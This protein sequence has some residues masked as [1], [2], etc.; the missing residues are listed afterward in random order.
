MTNFRPKV[1][2]YYFIVPNPK[3]IHSFA[4]N[5]LNMYKIRSKTNQIVIKA[6]TLFWIVCCQHLPVIAQNDTLRLIFTGDIMG[7]T[8][9]IKSAE[10]AKGVYDYKSCFQFVKPQL[11]AADLA[12]GNLEVTLPGKP[13]YT[14]YPMF[15]SPNALSTALKDAGFDVMVTAN[16]HSND[17]HGAGV[18]N[19]IETLRTEGFWQ[20]GT[21][22]NQKE[23]DVFYPLMLYKDK[24]K[25]AVLNYTYGTNGIPTEM[26]TIVNLLDTVQMA[27]DFAE[28]RARKPHFIIA[29]VHWGLEYQLTENADQRAMA[30]FMMRNGVDMIIGMHPHVVQPVKMENYQGKEVLVA[31]SLGNYISNQQQPNTDGGIMV[32]TELILKKGATKAVL[33]NYGYIPVWR[34]IHKVGAQPS[35]FVIPTA[36][37]DQMNE[38]FPA[39]PQTAVAKMEAFAMALRKRLGPAMEWTKK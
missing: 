20:T 31:Y 35:Y 37:A 16:N 38:L 26:P 18:T 9:Q 21:F 36:L 39:M 12:I 30:R 13:P 33:G 5:K 23:R 24:F 27:I 8:P 2:S 14:G 22:K 4:Q 19:T 3:K 10:K 34:Y 25:L 29:V 32:E 17:S 7:H 28:A 6:I 15:R 11:S 1:I